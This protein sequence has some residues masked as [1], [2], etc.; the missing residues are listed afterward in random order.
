MEIKGNFEKSNIFVTPQ[1][2]DDLWALSNI[3]EKGDI[4]RGQTFR[5]VN[6][7]DKNT[8]KSK[9]IIRKMFLKILVEKVNFSESILKILGTILEGPED[10]PLGTHHSFNIAIDDG[11]EIEKK[12]LNFQIKKLKNLSEK[13]RLTVFCCIFD[14]EEAII[15]KLQKNYFKKTI[16]LRGD[17]QKKNFEQNNSNF[18]EIIKKTLLEIDKQQ[19]PNYIIFGSSSFWKKTMKK[20]IEGSEIEKKS[21]FTTI[22]AINESG[23]AELVLKED[24]KIA[25]KSSD[26]MNDAKL[27]D[28]IFKRLSKDEPVC[29][30]V[31]DS[32]KYGE[33]GA[34]EKLICTDNLIK[35]LR[36]KN[37]FGDV[38]NLFKLVESQNG[39]VNILSGDSES[40][41]KLDGLGGIAGLLRYKI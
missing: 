16:E 23:F 25:L 31:K 36:E 6:I 21:I 39:E 15:G 13:E 4:V 8:E 18:F 34:I 9:V 24:V 38:E 37:L 41:N 27:I 26:A 10:I 2:V 32:I 5:K 35:E 40:I 20:E 14:R 3:I 17:V 12:W 33:L 22:D 30:G 29:Y 1:N 11:F 19:S 28:E 7:G